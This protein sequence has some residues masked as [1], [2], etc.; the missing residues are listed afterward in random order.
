MLD[1]I[2]RDLSSQST[3]GSGSATIDDPWAISEPVIESKSKPATHDW[4][5]VPEPHP[6]ISATENPSASQHIISSAGKPNAPQLAAASATSESNPLY[7]VEKYG[8][9]LKAFSGGKLANRIRKAVAMLLLMPA[10]R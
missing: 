8:M 5:F 9:K 4:H 10:W 6:L 7:L 3:S 1:N 2:S